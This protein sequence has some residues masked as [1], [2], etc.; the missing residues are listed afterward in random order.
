MSSVNTYQANELDSPLS[1]QVSIFFISSFLYAAKGYDNYE[2][3]IMGLAGHIATKPPLESPIAYDAQFSTLVIGL[4]Q[5]GW[6]WQ[7]RPTRHS[8]SP[9]SN[10]TRGV[11]EC[12]V[13]PAVPIN[14]SKLWESTR[15][16]SRRWQIYSHVLL[17][18]LGRVYAIKQKA[19]HRTGPSGTT[20]KS[21]R[22]LN[23]PCFPK[24]GGHRI[25]QSCAP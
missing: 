12:T 1:A 2:Q 17:I 4:A 24:D 9:Q 7:T 16:G 23:H 22:P 10:C 6:W 8:C 3:I 15:S 19:L 21:Y 5:T 13:F 20:L 25:S 14:I 11:S 18:G